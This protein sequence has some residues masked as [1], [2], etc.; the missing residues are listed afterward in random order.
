MGDKPDDEVAS[1]RA[2]LG[3]I[4]NDTARFGSG[5]AR[6]IWFDGRLRTFRAPSD[7]EKAKFSMQV[8]EQGTHARRMT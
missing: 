4:R 6:K 7:F 8:H 3:L 1:P 5:G 2:D